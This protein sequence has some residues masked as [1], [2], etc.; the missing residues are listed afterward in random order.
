M[1]PAPAKLNLTLRILRQRD[2]G[3]HELQTVFQFIDY[4]DQLNFNV[5]TDG[6][7]IRDVNMLDIPITQDLTVRAAQA[8]QTATNCKFGVNI[9]LYKQIPIGGG[10]GGGSSDAATTLLVLNKLW[11]LNLSVA[12]LLKIGIK[13][14]ADVPVFIKGIAAWAEGVGEKITPITLP[15]S[16]FLILIPPCQI[17]TSKIFAHPLLTRNSNPITIADFIAG[18]KINDCATI[19]RECYP[20]VAAALDWLETKFGK[21]QGRLTGTGACVFAEFDTELAA[22][23][24]LTTVPNQWQGFVAKGLNRSPTLDAIDKL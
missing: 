21:N 17:S 11:R 3:Y 18:N 12:N 7:I 9:Q 6:K 24:A 2:D 15:E 4:C 23:Q 14:G 10:L 13:L 20:P 1:Y 8:L 19:V 22:K 16:W 5:R